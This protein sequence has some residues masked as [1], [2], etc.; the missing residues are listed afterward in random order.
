[1]KISLSTVTCIASVA[2]I[3]LLACIGSAA[4][5]L[6]APEQSRTA[7]ELLPAAPPESA[8][9]K[10]APS[11]QPPP[12]PLSPPAVDLGVTP[13]SEIEADIALPSDIP[14]PDDLAAAAFASR[15]EVVYAAGPFTNSLAYSNWQGGMFCHRPLYF[16][17]FHLERQGRSFGV[18]QPAVSAAHFFAT[19][20]AMPYLMTVRPPGRCSYM[21]GIGPAGEPVFSPGWPMFAGVSR[22]HLSGAIVQAG[23]ITGMIFV[24]P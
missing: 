21:A 17:E 22:R 18:L 11:L 24:L 2:C 20:P 9:V 8:D 5:P 10:P 4:P 19:V 14:P 7:P 15:G 13:I 1:M 6:A 3:T 12:E 23:V 16:E